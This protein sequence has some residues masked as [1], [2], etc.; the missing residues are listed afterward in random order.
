[1]YYVI[2]VI[3]VLKNIFFIVMFFFNTNQTLQLEIIIY[4]L[5]RSSM[6][7][8]YIVLLK[9]MNIIKV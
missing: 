8:I 5:I 7:N 2:T 4:L 3:F 6:Y 9:Q 1:M